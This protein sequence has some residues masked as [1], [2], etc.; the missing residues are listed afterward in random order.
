MWGS[1]PIFYIYLFIFHG[2]KAPKRMHPDKYKNTPNTNNIHAITRNG[3]MR[4][5]V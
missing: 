4:W 1:D 2:A 5:D 3:F